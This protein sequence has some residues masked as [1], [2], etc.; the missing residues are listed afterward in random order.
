MAETKIFYSAKHYCYYAKKYKEEA[1]QILSQTQATG[2]DLDEQLK[3]TGASQI[4]L[5][6]AEGTKQIGLVEDVSTKQI[7]LVTAEGNTQTQR[8]TETGTAQVGLVTSK[9]DEKISAATK[10]AEIATEKANI[11]TE[12]ASLATEEANRAEQ[13]ASG[14]YNPAN[15][16]LSN[17]TQ[18]GELKL[19]TLPLS[20]YVNT[21]EAAVM[22]GDTTITLVDGQE[23]Y[24]YNVTEDSVITIDASN[25]SKTGNTITFEL[26]LY[27]ETVHAISYNNFLGWLNDSADM[28][29]NGKTYLLVFR[30]DDGGANWY[31]SFQGFLFA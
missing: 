5:V 28:S 11:A 29:E 31:G 22:A 17:L 12:K 25:L 30:S 9:G 18:T 19:K 1:Q 13:A 27:M 7:G 6:T 15:H 24:A 26:R 10:Q 2:K 21:T 3:A 20:L 14:V 23:V 16:D 8:V 4:G